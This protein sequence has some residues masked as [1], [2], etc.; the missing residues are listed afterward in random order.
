MA[1]LGHV[2][3]SKFVFFLVLF[4]FLRAAYIVCCFFAF[5]VCFRLFWDSFSILGGL[6]GFR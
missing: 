3:C 4:L 5:R 2:C 1:L 6:C